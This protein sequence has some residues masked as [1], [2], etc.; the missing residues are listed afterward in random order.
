MSPHGDWLLTQPYPF[1]KDQL[2]TLRFPSM[3]L[4][5]KHI[6]GVAAVAATAAIVATA[7]PRVASSAEHPFSALAGSW[8]GG[9]VVKKS[10]GGGERI[11]CRSTYEPVG[12]AQL[13]L[14]L[15]CASDSYNFDLSA[16]VAYEGGPIAGTWSEASRNVSGN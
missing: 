8:S 9:G 11:R 15:R 2:M 16:N 6:L 10:N 3:I 4:K 7:V 5:G 1:V 13:A 12:G 14:R